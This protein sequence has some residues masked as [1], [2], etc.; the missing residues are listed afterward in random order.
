MRHARAERG[1]LAHAL[2][3]GDERRG[4][5]DRPVAVGGVQVGV[6]D[7]AGVDPG[8]D[9]ARSR[10]RDGNLADVERRTEPGHDR[11]LHG[12]GQA[13]GHG[14]SPSASRDRPIVANCRQSL[15]RTFAAW[16]GAAAGRQARRDRGAA[17]TIGSPP[18]R[19]AT[20]VTVIPGWLKAA[21][22]PPAHHDR[23][24]QGRAQLDGGGKRPRRVERLG[25]NALPVPS[26]RPTRVDTD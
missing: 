1:D 16:V 15:N 21:P 13:F 7:A 26:R 14:P 17:Q 3:A 10:R 19:R 20:R 2:V 22:T 11:G 5:L 12:A 25:G 6:A 24:G 4:R 9:L 18:G 8:D 23:A